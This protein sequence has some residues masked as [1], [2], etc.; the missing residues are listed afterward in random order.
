MKQDSKI[1]KIFR[2]KGNGIAL[3]LGMNGDFYVVCWLPQGNIKMWIDY[4][5]W[6]EDNFDMWFEEL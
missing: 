6:Q 5:H 4:D 1:G 2:H 3:I